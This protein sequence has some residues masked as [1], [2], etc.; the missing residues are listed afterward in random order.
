[1]HD[2]TI[3]SLES[4]MDT[5]LNQSDPADSLHYDRIVISDLHLG[6]C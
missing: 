1:M 3:W 4:R 6:R 2:A 5:N